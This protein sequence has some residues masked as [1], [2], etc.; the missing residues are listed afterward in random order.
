LIRELLMRGR[1]RAMTTVDL[2]NL[3]GF[4]S[5][6]IVRMIQWLEVVIVWQESILTP[7]IVT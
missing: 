7:T 6:G 2:L 1:K 5:I 4:E 3:I